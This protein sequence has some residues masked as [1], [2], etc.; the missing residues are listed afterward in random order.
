[1]DHHLSIEGTDFTLSGAPFDMWGIRVANA[2]ESDRTAWSLVRHLDDYLEHGVNTLAIFLQ[3]ASTGHANPFDADGSFT[4][5]TRRAESTPY[6]KER[7]DLDGIAARNSHLDRLAALIEEADRRG[8]VVNIG[9]FYQA[10][11]RQLADDAAIC[12][13]T[14]NTA[15]W[16][17][18]KGYRNVFMDLVNE[19]GHNGFEGVG[20]CYGRSE[21]FA[22]DGG[23]ELLRIFKQTCP[24]IPA[25]ISASGPEPGN[26]PSADLILI[27]HVFDPAAVRRQAGREIP[28]V[29][30]EW[31]HG[32]IGS[33]SVEQTGLYTQ[34]EVSKW[35]EVIS[36]L[37]EGGGYV[38]YHAVWK[39]YM[40][41]HGGPSFELGPEDAQPQAT[42]TGAP[43]DHWYFDLVKESRGL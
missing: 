12:R 11:I 25:G 8:M 18:G 43:S 16:I 9:L 4:Q 3:G 1:M 26:F 36:T 27:H 38:F 37:R 41:E 33:G 21:R 20:L 35:K 19:Y 23:E 30:N 2:L 39:Q 34:E 17:A 6:L 31:G 15:R 22:L 14:E 24:D 29:L 10:R 42:Y 5:R 13:A 40:S 7:G 32:Q 28:V